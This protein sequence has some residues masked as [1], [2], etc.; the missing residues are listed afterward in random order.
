MWF[1]EL[2]GKSS[3]HVYVYKV[4][5]PR[6]TAEMVVERTAMNQHSHL[7]TLGVI[8]EFVEP[9]AETYWE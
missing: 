9:M 4:D 7:K 8:N 1:V 2:T 3:G 5:A 6:N